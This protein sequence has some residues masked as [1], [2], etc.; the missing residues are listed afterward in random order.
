VADKPFRCDILICP[1]GGGL[2]VTCYED[3]Q[4]LAERNRTGE[5]NS[6]MWRRALNGCCCA[7]WFA[8]LLKHIISCYYLP[9]ISS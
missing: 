6:V 3:E 2:V 1:T 9:L 5:E 4:R 7:F 8:T